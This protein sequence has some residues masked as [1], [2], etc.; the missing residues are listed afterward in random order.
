MKHLYNYVKSLVLPL[1]V[2]GSVAIQ[3]QTVLISPTGDGGFENGSTFAANGWTVS[4]NATGNQ[5]IIGT[6]PPGF[7]NNV[8]FI[9]NDGGVT[10]AF[11]NTSPTVVHFYRDITIPAGETNIVLSF[12][13]VA[14]GE[15]GFWD[16][17]M[18]SVA[19]TT[20]IPTATTTSLG[21][22]FLAGVTEVGRYWLQTTNQTVTV[23]IPPSA[24]NNCASAQTIRLIFSWKNDSSGGTNPPAAVDNISLTSQASTPLTPSP[25]LGTFTINNTLST[26]GTN[27]NNFTDAITWLNAAQ[28]ACPAIINPIIFNVSAGQTFTELP[29][30]IT[31]TGTAANTIT[32]QKSGAG[33]NPIVIGTNGVSTTN[34]GVLVVAGG[35]YFT[36][37]GIDIQDD[38]LSATT[39]TQ[40]EYGYVI[41][42]ANA[43][44]GALNNTIKNCN[45]SLNITRTT[46]I[47]ILVSASTTGGGATP[48]NISGTNSNNLIDSVFVENCGLGGILVTSGSATYPGS[49]NQVLHSTIGAG[50]VGIPNGSIGTGS[51]IAYGIQFNNQGDF[52]IQHNKIRNL[53]ST[54]TKRGIYVLGAQGISNVSHNIVQGVRNNSTTLTN[55]QRGMDLAMST[56]GTHTL[57]IYN[58]MIS[59]IMADF[60]G[61]ATATRVI[62]GTILGSGTATSTY[63]FD[64]NSISIDG[65]GSLTASN[66]CFELGG[67]T[68]TNNIRNNIFANY[69][70]AQTGVAKHYCI[71]STALAAM[72]SATSVVNFNDYYL[73]DITN[74]FTALT[75]TTDQASITDWDNAITTPSAPIDANSVAVDPQ[76]FDIKV[77]LHTISP[78]IAGIGDITGITWVTDDI[79]GQLRATPYDIG[80]DQ[81]SPPAAIDM[82]AIVLVS[83]LTGG[84]HT[85]SENVIVKIKNFAAQA[86][87][88]TTDNTTV[89]CNVT[90]AATQTFTVTLS[91]NTLNGGNP[92]ASGDSLDVPMGT[93]NM[94]T[95]GVY[96]FD[97]FTTVN[98]DG[99]PANNAMNSVNINV[100]AGTIS[101]ITSSICYGNGVTLNAS[102]YNGTIQWE[103]STDGGTTWNTITGATNATLV[104]SPLVNTDYR[105]LV[106]G[107]N[108]SNVASIAVTN[109]TPPTATG[110]TVCGQGSVTLTATGTG[111]LLWYNDS[112][113]GTPLAT[114]ASFTTNITA[115]DTFYVENVDGGGLQF[116]GPAN[117]T[118]VGT[119]ATW[120]STAQW[121]NFTVLQ[122][123]TLASVDMFFSS[124]IGTPFSIVI[125]DAI[126]LANVH[127]YNG[128]VS[129]SNA[130]PTTPQTVPVNAILAPGSY[131][132]NFGTATNTFRNSTGAVYPYEIPGALSITGNTFGTTYYYM[133]YNWAVFTG[134]S[135]ERTP[136]IAVTTPADSVFVN[137]SSSSICMGDSVTLFVTSSNTDYVYTWTPLSLTGDTINATPT[138]TTTY[139]VNANDANTGCQISDSITVSVSSLPVFNISTSSTTIC[140]GNTAQLF[141]NTASAYCLPT[142]GSTGASGDYIESVVF[143]DLSNLN[144]G[145][146]PSDYQYYSSLTANVIADGTTPYTLTLTPGSSWSQHLRVWIDFNQ[147]G[148][149]EA[150]ESIYTTTAATTTPVTTSVTI[151]NT[152]INGLTRMRVGCR[153]SSA[154]LATEACGHTGFGEYEDYNVMITGGQT[155]LTYAWTPSASLNNASIFNPLATPNATTTYYVDVTNG[156]G[157]TSTDSVT[158]NVNPSPIVDL[159]ADTLICGGT[160]ITL[161]AGNTGLSFLWNDNSTNQTLLVTA[162]GTYT[163]TVTESVNNCST[164]DSIAVAFGAVATVTLPSDTAICAGASL[165]IDAGSGY[166]SY[167]WSNGAQTQTTTVTT[168][169]TYTVTITNNDG[170]EAS[171]DI[172][173]TLN[174][175]PTVN[176]GNDTTLCN[177]QSIT[178][179]AGAGFASY[180]WTPSGNTQTITATGANTT[181]TY[182][183]TVTDNNGCSNTDAITVTFTTC[184]GEK[185]EVLSNF[186]NIY[187]NPNN[188]NFVVE[189]SGLVEDTELSI[190]DINGREI[191]KDVLLNNSY[192]SKQINMS[193]QPAGVYLL[194]LKNN[195]SVQIVRISKY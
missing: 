98:F 45:V 126:T 18:V 166:T 39:T 58:N 13:W 20:Y 54:G 182:T 178:L 102:G 108:T 142:V 101:S 84:C 111:T 123:L 3:A 95:P 51:T 82:G 63:N 189:L 24:V 94:T 110:D 195:T 62:I 32:F 16:A 137:A 96:T 48:T 112:I 29:P 140:E 191:Y 46:A 53:V 42:N 73:L 138:N 34:D 72:G 37:D 128:T 187:P 174:A 171:D 106:C 183:V 179:N 38:P 160:D 4:N 135:S 188:G 7:N 27:F 107:I 145:D 31:A 22:A 83:P 77:D 116:V 185:E 61:T 30:V 193:T 70:G 71:R 176:L 167:N 8:A 49:N 85:T 149:F 103:Y 15:T 170:C 151:P 161:D 81:F 104:D 175:L 76:F 155:A 57:N 55:S 97:A 114:G 172:I 124:A 163:V 150:S 136:V 144:S 100:S 47:G 127:T 93:L 134:C 169:G 119:F 19:P 99:A 159:G 35:D 66:V 44:D 69:T 153:Y 59:D 75:N 133:F 50:Y 190:V 165:T 80:A 12:D 118:I 90:G 152:A 158:I 74:G 65:S 36:F 147:N 17:L 186:I 177:N 143:A 164:T 130:T 67:S 122:P 115:T 40:M 121:M 23:N 181:N 86:I 14:N 89:T 33:A 88:F 141:A 28:N 192:V 157:C 139:V 120:N 6:T 5:W 68:T 168:G 117:P 129:V 11:T 162:N 156:A 79:D 113:G 132:I 25:T 91:N 173:V 125:R 92:L 131:Q 78:N 194:T 184:V 1:L 105:L 64:F 10:H 148:V 109:V 43:T 146:N 56:T 2:I 87:D 41:R 21:T 52:N 26:G 154:L 60:T 9:S 180:L